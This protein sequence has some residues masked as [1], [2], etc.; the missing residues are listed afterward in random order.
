VS[1]ADIATPDAETFLVIRTSSKL[2]KLLITAQHLAVR[3]S[4]QY[5]VSR[6]GSFNSDYR[7]ALANQHA[8]VEVFYYWW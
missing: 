4:S 5:K 8:G 1:C 3:H 6:V 2:A 7:F